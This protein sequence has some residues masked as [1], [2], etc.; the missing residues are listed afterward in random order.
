IAFTAE[1][2]AQGRIVLPPP[3][4]QYAG[5]K[6]EVAIVGVNNS[7]ELWDKEEWEAEKTRSQQEAW[8]IIESLEKR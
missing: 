1:M 3:L 6:D 8:Q 7:L 2:D 5:I 4:R